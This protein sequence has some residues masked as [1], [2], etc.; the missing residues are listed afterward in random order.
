[1]SAPFAGVFDEI[2]RTRRVWLN[3]A[4]L[5]IE[6]HDPQSVGGHARGKCFGRVEGIA[7][8]RYD[9][10]GIP[11]RVRGIFL[12]GAQRMQ[13]VAPPVTLSLVYVTSVFL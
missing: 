10:F 12:P 2:A 13:Q 5:T 11:R 9:H 7:H 6:K 8:F 1:V 4:A 3:D